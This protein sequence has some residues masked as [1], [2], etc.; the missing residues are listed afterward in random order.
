MDEMIQQMLQTCPYKVHLVV[1]DAKTDGFFHSQLI[2][3]VFSSASVIKV[4]I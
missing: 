3:E 1:K 2:D 4:P